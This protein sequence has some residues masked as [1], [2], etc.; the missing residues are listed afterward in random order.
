MT[1]RPGDVL[2]VTR[3]TQ[4]MEALAATTTDDDFAFRVSMAALIISAPLT[5]QGCAVIGK[6]AAM[7]VR[8]ILDSCPPGWVD[9]YRDLVERLEAN[10]AQVMGP[11]RDKP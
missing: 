9:N 5:T 6:A 4:Q 8:Q 10:H 2:A 7:A 1:I 3:I 11:G